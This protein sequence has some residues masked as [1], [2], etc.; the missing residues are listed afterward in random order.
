MFLTRLDDNS[1]KFLIN[2]LF[3]INYI[4][5]VLKVSTIILQI[6]KGQ[7]KFLLE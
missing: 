1:T 3:L 6:N 2:Q 7:R 5:Y 4:T